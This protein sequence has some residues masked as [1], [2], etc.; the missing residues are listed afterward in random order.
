MSFS[1]KIK[2]DATIKDV[3]QKAG[4]ATGTVSRYMNG[5]KIR[6]VNR[7]NIENAI[8]ETG[9][10]ENYLAKTFKTKKN[11]NHRCGRC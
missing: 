5:Y 4:V 9:Y 3:A 11:F 10:R 1:R 8:K 2:K 6:E 7:I